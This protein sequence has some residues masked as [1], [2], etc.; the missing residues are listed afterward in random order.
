MTDADHPARPVSVL[1]TLFILALFGIFLFVVRKAYVPTATA[2][3]NAEAENFSKDNSWRAT[4]ANRRAA[5]QELREK[6]AKQATSY[7]WVD[8]KAGV[9]QLPIERAMQLTAEKYGGKK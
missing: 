6:Q 3:H 8:Q 2:P 4:D 9:V 5:L 7:G 1:T